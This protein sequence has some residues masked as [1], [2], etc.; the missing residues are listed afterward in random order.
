MSGSVLQ[1]LRLEHQ[2]CPGPLVPQVEAALARHGRPLR[3]AITAVQPG[4]GNST[5]LLIEAVV[6]AAAPQP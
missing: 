5:S 2:R 4:P 3:W 1:P 6:L